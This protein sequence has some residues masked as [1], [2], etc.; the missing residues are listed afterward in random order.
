MNIEDDGIDANTPFYLSSN[1]QY[2]STE[3]FPKPVNNNLISLL[4]VNIRSLPKNVDQLEVFLQSINQQFSV[5]ALS[6]TWLKTVPHSYYS[7]PGYELI[8]NNR[9]GNKAGGGV[10]LY[11]SRDLDVIPRED[12]N[13]SDDSLE[14]LFIE[15]TVPKSKNIIAGVMY[16]A[17]S[18][19][20]SEFLTSFQMVCSHI[21]YGSKPCIISGDFNINMLNYANPS[22][23]SFI[24]LLT[25]HSFLPLIEK[26]TRITDTS[27]T[28][29]DNIWSN[30]LPSPESG[31]LLS[32]ISD[33]LP[34]FTFIQSPNSNAEFSHKNNV[35]FTRNFSNVNLQNVIANLHLFDWTDVFCCNNSETAYNT[36]MDNFNYLYDK[37]IPLVRYNPKTKSSHSSKTPWITHSLFKS[38]NK[39]NKLYRQYLSNPTISH[40]QVH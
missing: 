4:H 9:T 28:L 25:S 40:N 29:I 6:E 21:A 12:L 27:A 23:Q 2:Y 30:I 26:P 16:K 5:I 34:I 17:P 24:D 15:I 7:L 38:I 13:L 39:K 33:H 11:V 32:D 22:S 19:V 20:H 31:V 36:F 35:S 3:Q 8:V 14:S 10:A 37:N 1:S 18:V